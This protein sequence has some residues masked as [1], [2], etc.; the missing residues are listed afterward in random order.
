MKFTTIF[1]GGDIH[2]DSGD[3]VRDVKRAAG[4]RKS[5]GGDPG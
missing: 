4:S 5:G 3:I 1:K 2:L